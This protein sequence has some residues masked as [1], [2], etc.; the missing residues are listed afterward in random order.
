V[1]RQQIRKFL[2]AVLL[3][4]S[5]FAALGWLRPYEW[6]ADPAARARVKGVQLTPDQSY[7]WLEVH[8][9]V[10]DGQ[11]HQLEKPVDLVTAKGERLKAADTVLGGSEEK[12]TTDLWVKF[13]LRSDQIH[14]PLSLNLNDGK[15]L[16]RSRHGVPDL[17]NN[18]PA[19][20]TTHRW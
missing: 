1:Q 13:W 5:A 2:W 19:F 3:L 14:G 8:L 7:F 6:G 18:R 16:I 20:F 9:K 17:E 10:V 11:V 4:A 15:L 12:G